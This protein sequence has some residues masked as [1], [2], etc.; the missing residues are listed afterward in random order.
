MPASEDAKFKFWEFVLYNET[1]PTLWHTVQLVFST[2]NR[3][4][5][6]CG[7]IYRSCGRISTTFHTT[8]LGSIYI[9][10]HPSALFTL[11]TLTVTHA[12]ILKQLLHTMWLGNNSRCHTSHTGSENLRTRTS[13]VICYQWHKEK[14]PHVALSHLHQLSLKHK[15]GGVKRPNMWTMTQNCWQQQ[16]NCP[17]NEFSN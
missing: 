14:T 3:Q 4:R 11:K 2:W 13:E 10:C 7:F 6:W 5:G 1:V 17:S 9:W 15:C 12:K 16:H 8:T